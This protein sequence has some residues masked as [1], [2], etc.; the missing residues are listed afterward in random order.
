MQRSDG[1]DSTASEEM[2]RT[3]DDPEMPTGGRVVERSDSLG[4]AAPASTATLSDLSATCAR[5]DGPTEIGG[6]A[7][8]REGPMALARLRSEPSL[9]R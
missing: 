4:R 7:E 2:A 8:K 9:N 5:S 3:Q 1:R 6:L